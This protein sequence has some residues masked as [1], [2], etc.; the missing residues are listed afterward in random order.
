MRL[1]PLTKIAIKKT[2][3]TDRQIAP[4]PPAM[5]VPPTTIAAITAKITL[6]SSDAW[7]DVVRI[8]FSAPA[9]PAPKP[10]KV[11]AII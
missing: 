3:A 11:N 2:P 4:D 7:A 8:E 6:K 9:R 5:D 10:P 1:N